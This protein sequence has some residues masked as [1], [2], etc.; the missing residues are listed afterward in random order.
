MV[1]K[2]NSDDILKQVN[3]PGHPEAKR[4]NITVQKMRSMGAG[5]FRV[6]VAQTRECLID[7]RIDGKEFVVTRN[8]GRGRYVVRERRADVAADF[9]SKVS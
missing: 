4:V 8:L 1:G 7:M 2:F 9:N 6:K 5:R 3:T